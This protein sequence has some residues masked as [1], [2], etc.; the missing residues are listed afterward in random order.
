M[1]AHGKEP[2]KRARACAEGDGRD[3][4]IWGQLQVSSKAVRGGLLCCCVCARFEG[5]APGWWHAFLESLL[6]AGLDCLD[7]LAEKG[8]PE[9]KRHKL[10][11]PQLMSLVCAVSVLEREGAI[12]LEISTRLNF[13]FLAHGHGQTTNDSDDSRCPSA[14]LSGTA[15][16]C[17]SRHVRR[18]AMR[19][20]RA[21]KANHQLVPT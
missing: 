19:D 4:C 17:V 6:S 14:G 13:V 20:A 15:I 2:G 7:C 1:C 5:W 11:T 10:E 8:K 9:S 21:P 12:T 3:I 16:A 18:H